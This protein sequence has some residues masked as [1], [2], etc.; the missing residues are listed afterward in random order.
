MNNSTRTRSR[1]RSPIQRPNFQPSGILAKFSN[2]R[3][4]KALKYTEP[5]DASRPTSHWRV[6]IFKDE[7]ELDPIDLHTSSWYLIGRDLDVVD[8]LVANPS[9]SKQ[10]AA[11]QYRMRHG[12]VSLYI[13]DLQSTNGTYL[14]DEKLQDSRYYRIK[15][16]DVI[17]FGSSTRKYVMIEG[18]SL[19]HRKNLVSN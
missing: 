16:K 5:S 4:S 2:S 12:K 19:R 10:H 18:E 7:Q 13:I 1:S 6:F 9:V 8:I 17:T 15:N 14:N 3:G 11:F